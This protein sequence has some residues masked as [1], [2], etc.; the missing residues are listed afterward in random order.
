MGNFT[1][2]EIEEVVERKIRERLAGEG[3]EESATLN[4]NPS[5]DRRRFLKLAGM[6]IGV[7]SFSSAT[8]AWSLI[9][10][11]DQGTSDLDAKTL[12]GNTSEDLSSNGYS[13]VE[14]IES[15]TTWSTPSEADNL[16]VIV[17]GGGAGGAGVDTQG[18]AGAGGGAGSTA[19][20]VIENPSSSYSVAIGSGGAG[21]Q[22]TSEMPNDGEDSSFGGV[23]GRGGKSPYEAGSSNNSGGKGGY[24]YSD[25]GDITLSGGGGSAGGTS[26]SNS[27]SGGDGYQGVV[28]VFY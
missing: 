19:I 10:P 18:D 23:T 3:S 5:I 22:S 1:E 8:S 25:D 14:V 27:I 9:Q 26:T 21:S 13:N 16:L 17:T 20:S 7:L 4:E 12:Q 24:A 28:I 2:E 11:Q 6:G 15:D